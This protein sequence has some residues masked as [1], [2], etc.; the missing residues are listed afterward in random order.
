MTLN[1]HLLYTTEHFTVCATLCWIF[2]V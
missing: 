2:F 1:N